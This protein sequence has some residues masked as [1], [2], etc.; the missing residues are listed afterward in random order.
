MPKI[1]FDVKLNRPT[2]VML[3]AAFGGDSHIVSLFDTRL[4]LLHPTEDLVMMHGTFQEW[5]QL[6]TT[7]NAKVRMK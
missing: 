5:Q 4:W 1:V 7:L 3:Q 2:C 6:A